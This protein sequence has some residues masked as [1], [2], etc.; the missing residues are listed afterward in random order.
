MK[1]LLTRHNY[2]VGA[3]CAMLEVSRSGYY[4]WRDRPPSARVQGDERLGVAIRAT[5][6]ASRQTYGTRR[7]H[8]QLLA[9]GVQVGRDR[10][11]RLRRQLGLGCK[12]KRSFRVTTDS[13][14]TL[15]VADNLLQQE[16]AAAAP[17]RVWL[18]K[19]PGIKRIY[20]N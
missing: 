19:A 9:H 7:V 15:P 3:V 13:A 18:K 4:A 20:K 2:P 17:D 8:A 5:H 14:H 10:V 1:Q 12:Q 6:E 16:F 11:G